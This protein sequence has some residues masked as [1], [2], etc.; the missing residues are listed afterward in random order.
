MSD[1]NKLRHIAK[2]Q[3]ADLYTRNFK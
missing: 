1:A 2:I 3:S